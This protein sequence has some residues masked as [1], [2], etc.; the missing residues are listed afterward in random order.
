MG[1]VLANLIAGPL[2][3]SEAFGWPSVFYLFGSVGALW[4]IPWI[5]YTA[6]RLTESEARGGGSRLGRHSRATDHATDHTDEFEMGEFVNSG[7]RKSGDYGAVPLVSREDDGMRRP[8]TTSLSI[9]T[10][11]LGRR[12][13]QTSDSQLNAPDSNEHALESDVESD[14][15]SLELELQRVSLDLGSA[16]TGDHEQIDLVAPALPSSTISRPATGPENY[17]DTA[18]LLDSSTRTARIAKRTADTTAPTSLPKSVPWRKIMTTREVWA[19]M[20]VQFCQVS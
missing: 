19:I 13:K 10:R 3:A 7:T 9:S 5:M 11:P 2:I 18:N 14:D 17:D 8:S 6:P 15:D 16:A 12:Q 20:G 4:L 1:A